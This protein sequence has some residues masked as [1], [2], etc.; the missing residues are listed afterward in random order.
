MNYNFSKTTN[1]FSIDHLQGLLDTD[2]TSAENYIL[3]YFIKVDNDAYVM[4]YKN[5]ALVPISY[6]ICKKIY[7]KKSLLVT[8]KR[9]KSYSYQSWLFENHHDVY[10]QTFD[11]KKPLLYSDDKGGLFVNLFHGYPHT[12]KPVEPFSDETMK[13]VNFI[14]N[15]VKNVLCSSNEASY[16]YTKNWVSN[17]FLRKMKTILVLKALQGTGKSCFT[18][19]LTEIVGRRNVLETCEPKLVFG[20]FNDSVKGKILIV[21][22]EMPCAST[23]EWMTIAQKVKLFVTGKTIQ[24]KEKNKNTV[25]IPNHASVIINSNNECIKVDSDDRRTFCLDV[26][27]CKKGDNTY[28]KELFKYLENKEVQEAFYWTSIETADTKFREGD[29]MPMTTTKKDLIVENMHSIYSFIK[30]RYVLKQKGINTTF[31]N[32]YKHYSKYCETNKIKDI[33]LIATSK[34]LKEYN[35]PVTVGSDNVRF[36]VIERDTLVQLYKKMNWIHDLDEFNDTSSEAVSEVSDN[37]ILDDGYSEEAVEEPVEA[38]KKT[39]K[40]GTKHNLNSI[41]KNLLNAFD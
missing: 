13:G 2:L 16:K 24:I 20:D 21:F 36:V 9:G 11:P 26:S 28:F 27:N 22:E 3:S 12:T 10:H 32:F 4:M 17:F 33:S 39:K 40:T 30:Q 37:K 18:E 7:L 23:G 29:D 14:W 25:E 31:K 35:I 41:D 34:K 15:H 5:K 6:E 1:E 8:P 19:F 38:V